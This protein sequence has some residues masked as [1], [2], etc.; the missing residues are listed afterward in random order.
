MLRSLRTLALLIIVV[1]TQSANAQLKQA[2]FTTGG[3]YMGT[4]NYVKLYSYNP[5]NQTAGVIDSVFGD[6]SNELIADSGKAYMH[7]GRSS[8]FANGDLIVK[9]D[10]LT[11]TKLDSTDQ[12]SGVQKFITTPKYLVATFGYGATGDYVRFYNKN[13]MDLVF[14]DNTLPDMTSAVTYMYDSVYVA[15]NHN[16]TG[17]I[18]VYSLNPIARVR[19][20]LFDTLSAGVNGIINN[21]QYIAMIGERF[22][23]T[24]FGIDYG[25]ITRFDP[26]TNMHSTFVLDYASSLIG[27]DQDTVFAEYGIPNSYLISNFN[28]GSFSTP[29]DFT[30]GAYDLMAHR[31][32]LQETDYYS[33]GRM[34]VI[35]RSNNIID[36]VATDISG[37][38]VALD[39]FGSPLAVKHSV[40]QTVSLYP[41][42]SHDMIN[43]KGVSAAANIIIY[44]NTGKIV[45][46][47]NSQV[48]N[49][50]SLANGLYNIFITDVTG[51]TS[52]RFIK[53]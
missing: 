43:I 11:H 12:A 40:K 3:I 8:S 33:F 14:S 30:E 38:A 1:S 24:T 49:V 9:Y 42:P 34:I 25:S 37:A 19:T 41:N 2:L 50:S 5:Y 7:V 21:G 32:Y 52:L 15:Y 53:N 45:A 39:Y 48:V 22:N 6:F 46:T 27:M 4:G 29:I 26:V 35:D 51:S 31:F 28:V 13:T 23:F 18:A 44:D 20:V 17:A 36:T 16:D 10:L 47:G